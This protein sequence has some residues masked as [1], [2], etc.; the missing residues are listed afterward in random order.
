MAEPHSSSSSSNSNK[1]KVKYSVKNPE[2]AGEPPPLK[3][4]SL[5][6]I[7]FAKTYEEAVFGWEAEGKPCGMTRCKAVHH[8]FWIEKLRILEIYMTIGG[9]E[10]GLVFELGTLDVPKEF[11]D[12]IAQAAERDRPTAVSLYDVATFILSNKYDVYINCT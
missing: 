5:V 11:K 8:V 4:A 10:Q 2:T 9:K 3:I 6:D 7:A 12:P 1:P